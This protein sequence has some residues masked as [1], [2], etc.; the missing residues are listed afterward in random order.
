MPTERVKKI[1]ERAILLRV[2]IRHR[3]R[4]RKKRRA[5]A[6]AIAST[7]HTLA[8]ATTPIRLALVTVAGSIQAVACAHDDSWSVALSCPWMQQGAAKTRKDA[9]RVTQG[10]SENRAVFIG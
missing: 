8:G 5:R 4:A 9:Q 10:E 7:R 1:I 6:Q 2:R 3:S